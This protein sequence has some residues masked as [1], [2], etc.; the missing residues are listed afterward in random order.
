MR[1]RPSAGIRG[2][3]RAPRGHPYCGAA[4]VLTTGHCRVSPLQPC[5]PGQVPQPSI[6]RPAIRPER[7]TW[8]AGSV[9]SPLSPL[10]GLS[11]HTRNRNEVRLP[12][13]RGS[14]P[15]RGL[16]EPQNHP[17]SCFSAFP[18]GKTGPERLSDL[19]GVTQREAV[20]LRCESG[21]GLPQAQ[22]LDLD[23]MRDR[24]QSPGGR[25]TTSW[26][27][28]PGPRCPHLL[29]RGPSSSD[30]GRARQARPGAGSLWVQPR[31]QE[32]GRLGVTA[33]ASRPGSKFQASWISPSG[34]SRGRKSAGSASQSNLHC[35]RISCFRGAQGNRR[36]GWRVPA[37]V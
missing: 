37:S 33:Q 16:P 22:A 2:L 30:H 21:S 11:K 7:A 27:C 4:F 28:L 10:P 36:L 26:R 13:S 1:G 14:A 25:G 18:L 32:A 6:R 31:H 5:G 35:G 8:G 23:G 12:V 17:R 3:F 34:L 9:A 19:L 24:V 15:P 29:Q 20:A